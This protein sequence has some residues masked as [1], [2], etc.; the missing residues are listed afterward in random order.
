MDVCTVFTRSPSKCHQELLSLSPVFFCF[1]PH[2][3]AAVSWDIYPDSTFRLSC[4]SNPVGSK[5]WSPWR[6]SLHVCWKYSLVFQF[7]LFENQ[8]ALFLLRLPPSFGTI[9]VVFGLYLYLCVGMLEPQN[10]RGSRRGVPVEE[11]QGKMTGKSPKF[12]EDQRSQE[13]NT[14]NPIP[15][16]GQLFCWSP[17]QFCLCLTSPFRRIFEMIYTDA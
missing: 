15:W 3:P 4:S 13:R 1:S 16:W 10:H 6:P 5:S 2:P 11:G 14:I 17:E 9:S 12:K 7:C 8:L